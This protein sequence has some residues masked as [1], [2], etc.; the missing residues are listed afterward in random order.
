MGELA[1]VGSKMGVTIRKVWGTFKINSHQFFCPLE[2]YRNLSYRTAGSQ[3]T[4]R[5]DSKDNRCPWVSLRC[6]YIIWSPRAVNGPFICC[7]GCETNKSTFSEAYN[8]LNSKDIGDFWSGW[9]EGNTIHPI[10]PWITTKNTQSNSLRIA[11]KHTEVWSTTLI[12]KEM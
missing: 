5:H 1:S 11:S 7:A 4:G 10:L 9:N 8:K 12:I 3:Q 6:V 2:F